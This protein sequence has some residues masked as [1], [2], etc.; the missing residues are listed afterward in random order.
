MSG[1]NCQLVL[2]INAIV[3]K[4]PFIRHQLLLDWELK[5][6][7]GVISGDEWLLQSQ[8]HTTRDGNRD[9]DCV[10]SSWISV[11]INQD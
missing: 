11:T 6:L 9:A 4:F 10:S 7:Y 8:Q 2:F 3:N 1:P 5:H